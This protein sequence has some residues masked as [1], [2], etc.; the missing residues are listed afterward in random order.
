[1]AAMAVSEEG[2]AYAADFDIPV[3]TSDSRVIMENP[4]IETVMI[5]SPTSSHADYVM[6]AAEAGK[7]IF[8]EKPLDLSVKKV[9]QTLNA[10][11]KANVPLMLAFNQRFDENFSKVRDYVRAGE[12]GSVHSL[13]IISRDP[14]PPPVGY[15]RTSGGLFMDMTI[16]DFDMARF[17]TGS[18]VIEVFAKGYNLVDPEIG[19]AGDI[20]TGIALLTFDNSA[21][22]IIENSR[23]AVYGYDQRLEVF[24]ST[25]LMRAENTLKN[26]STFFNETGAHQARHLDFFMD[27]YMQSYMTEVEA[28]LK[29]LRD[30]KPMPVTGEDGLK[31]MLIA[32]AANTSMKENRPVKL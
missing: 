20:D 27:R 29:A 26:T 31:A 7:N 32:E 5:C 24:G 12:L 15:I 25:G 17:I 22:A 21:T 14:A 18:E 28:F 8:C 16:H 11:R 6:Q 13:H 1:V 9:K 3:V 2:R 23:K 10:V 30:K 4:E 19:E